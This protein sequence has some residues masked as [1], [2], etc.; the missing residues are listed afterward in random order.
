MPA[1]GKGKFQQG[2]SSKLRGRWHD[3]NSQRRMRNKS[4]VSWQE[5]QKNTGGGKSK[6][7]KGKSA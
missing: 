6:Y 2:K 3:L 7:T 1:K 4:T 5:Y